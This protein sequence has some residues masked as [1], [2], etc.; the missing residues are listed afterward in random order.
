M[1]GQPLDA[2]APDWLRAVLPKLQAIVAGERGPELARDMALD[3]ANAV[4]LRLL[5]ERLSGPNGG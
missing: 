3:Y 4:E 5:L 1:L 2:E